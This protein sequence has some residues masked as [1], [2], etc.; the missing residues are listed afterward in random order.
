MNQTI[1]PPDVTEREINTPTLGLVKVFVQ[2]NIEE[3]HAKTVFITCHDIGTNHRSFYPFIMHP[4]MQDMRKHSIFLH[5][6]LPGQ[7]DK[8][9][10]LPTGYQFPSLDQIGMDFAFILD[11]FNVK[12]VFGIG[13]GAGA[14]IICRFALAHPN[15][16]LGVI[17]IHCTSTTAGVMEYIKD[18]MINWKLSTNGMNETAW[19]YLNFHKFGEAGY[20]G[21]RDNMISPHMADLNQRIQIYLQDLHERMNPTNLGQYLEAFLKRSDLSTTLGTNLKVDALL[22][23]GT[24]ASHLHTVYTMYQAMSKSNSSLLLVDDVGDAMGEAPTKLA[25]ALILFCKGLGVFGGL[26]ISNMKSTMSMEEVIHPHKPL[27]PKSAIVGM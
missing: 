3:L 12:T 13:E 4:S 11:A 2:G 25:R 15:R 9:P 27:D 23:V 18:K 24:R 6:C 10:N 1:N 5:V 16:V 22:V 19:E 20:V 14:N 26:A 7:D 17:L 8:A 21:D